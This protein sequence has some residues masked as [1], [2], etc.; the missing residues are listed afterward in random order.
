MSNQP[1]TL[2]LANFVAAGALSH[3]LCQDAATELRRQHALI[4]ELKQALQSMIEAA[5]AMHGTC[6]A[7][8]GDTPEDADTFVHDKWA[9][10]FLKETA[11]E[12]LV[13]LAKAEAQQ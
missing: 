13:I 7:I 11:D 10:D 12:S 3:K 8:Y 2:W 6:G 1:E 9:E 4:Q 5:G